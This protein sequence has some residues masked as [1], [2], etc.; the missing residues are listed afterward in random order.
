MCKEVIN[1][2]F[3]TFMLLMHRQRLDLKKNTP[4]PKVSPRTSMMSEPM[5]DSARMSGHH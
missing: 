1:I 2:V 4:Y 3:S 5:P